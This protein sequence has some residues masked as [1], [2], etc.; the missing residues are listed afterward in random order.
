[1]EVAIIGVIGTLLGTI[2]GWFLNFF[3]GRGKIIAYLSSWNDKFQYLDFGE[4]KNSS[5]KDKTEY[6]EC[7]CSIDIYN[8]S[9]ETKIL[10]NIRM[11]FCDGKKDVLSVIP[12]DESTKR[13]ACRRTVYDDIVSQ[14]IPPHSV[15]TLN[16][17]SGV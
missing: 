12:N 2:L 15:I 16:L 9:A 8:S 1:M 6:F 11:V 5:C 14:N 13:F 17:L 3:S 10:R 4:M 7:S